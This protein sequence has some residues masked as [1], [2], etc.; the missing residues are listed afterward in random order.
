MQ[1]IVN[2]KLTT[3]SYSNVANSILHI[4]LFTFWKCLAMIFYIYI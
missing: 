3:E 4:C 2:G 1:V